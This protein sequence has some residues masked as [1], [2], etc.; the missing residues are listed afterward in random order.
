[1]SIITDEDN[2]S[3]GVTPSMTEVRTATNGGTYTFAIVSA[4]A[5]GVALVMKGE[6]VG[7]IRLVWNPVN[8]PE[9]AGYKLYYGQTSGNYEYSIDVGNQTTYIVTGQPARQYYFV[10]TAYDTDGKESLPSQELVYRLPE[11]QQIVYMPNPDFYGQDSFLYEVKDEAGTS[12]IGRAQVTVRPVND[13]PVAVDD[14]VSTPEETAVTIDVLANDT[15]VDGDPLQVVAFAQATYGRVVRNN[16][17]TF[18]YT[19]ALDFYG[20]DSFEYTI[21]DAQGET[22]TATV[23]ITVLPVRD[24]PI[25]L[26]LAITVGEAGGVIRPGDILA[27]DVAND[28]L[29]RIEVTQPLFGVVVVNPDGTLT[30]TPNANVSGTDSFDYTVTDGSGQSATATV[31]I[32]ITTEQLVNGDFEQGFTAWSFVGDASI[33]TAS[34]MSRALLTTAGPVED[35]GDPVGTAVPITDLATFLE[36]AS[37]EINSIST[38]PIF[39]GSAIKRTFTARA[40]TVLSFDWNFLTNEATHLDAPA[41]TPN[42]DTNDLAFVII[43]PVT[44][45]ADTLRT[46]VLSPTDFTSETGF[47]TFTFT[48]PVTGTYTLR[49]GVADVGDAGGLSGLLIDNVLLTP[50]AN[51]PGP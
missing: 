10:V 4:P 35:S 26:A 24:A 16:N 20:T 11:T 15:D 29:R 51:L 49:I 37:G 19:P 17:G 43:T 21:S 42:P 2:L 13:A 32:T 14:A 3:A 34:G 36:I 40:E 41:L 23:L 9:I 1:M 6:W 31:T 5:N 50:G 47:E 22:A 48:V 30:Y 25:A 44:R 27:G 28:P 18:T 33:V 46:F 7:W 39:A 8:E 45:L 38:G 12:V